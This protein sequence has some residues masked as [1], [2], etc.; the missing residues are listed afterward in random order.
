MKR[1]IGIPADGPELT[2]PISQHFGHCKYFIGVEVEDGKITGKSFSLE[3]T[4]HSSCME[5]VLNM[6]D[7]RVTDM[8]VGGIGGRP[9]MGFLQVG[10]N[11][12]QGEEGSIKE[13][14]ELLLQGKLK[15]LG[16]PSCGGGTAHAQPS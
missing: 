7:R 10:I 9:Y 14:V 3:N 5:P 11:L 13:N 2:D 16:G 12:Y 1:V 8:I 6:R 15:A 4:G